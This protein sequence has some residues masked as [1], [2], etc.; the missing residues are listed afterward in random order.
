MVYGLF[1]SIRK[2]SLMFLKGQ[3][4]NMWQAY[5]IQPLSWWYWYSSF[6]CKCNSCMQKEGK[7]LSPLLWYTTTLCSKSVKCRFQVTYIPALISLY[8]IPTSVP[9][10]DFWN[11]PQI[12]FSRTHRKTQICMFVSLFIC[13]NFELRTA[14]FHFALWQTNETNV[15]WKILSWGVGLWV[16]KKVKIVFLKYAQHDNIV[17]SLSKIIPLTLL[18]W[19]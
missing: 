11:S 5:Q 10:Q 9:V 8:N 13:P 15:N 4:Y 17:T 7:M 2:L 16:R 14:F 1:A 12:N 6:I 18:E 19:I 3:K